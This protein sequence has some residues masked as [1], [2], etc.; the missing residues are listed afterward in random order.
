MRRD[1]IASTIDVTLEGAD[2]LVTADAQ[3]IRAAMLNLLLN[4]AQSMDGRGSI[5]VSLSHAG[6][7]CIQ[8]QLTPRAPT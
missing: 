6:G 3:M 7:Q 4:A 8:R 1:P 5:T 2:V